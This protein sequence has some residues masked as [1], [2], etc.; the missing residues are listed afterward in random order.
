[1]TARTARGPALAAL[2][3][4]AFA[5]CSDED[6][7]AASTTVVT[8]IP[9]TTT[10]E[11]DDQVL[12]LGA[13]LPLSGAGAEL[14]ASMLAAVELAVEQ[15]NDAGGVG[16]APVELVTADEGENAV[17][18]TRGVEELTAADVDA[19]IGPASSVVALDVLVTLR[20]E[21]VLTCSPSATS[22]ALD[23]FPDEGLFFRT[24]PSDS[25]QAEAIARLIDQTGRAS[26]SILYVDD[27]YGRPLTNALTARLSTRAVDVEALVPFHTDDTDYEDEVASALDSGA[28]V[29]AVIGDPS[30]GARVLATA[31]AE[32]EGETLQII[33]NDALR[34]ASTGNVL[35]SFDE[36][37]IDRVTGV[38]VRAEVV[39]TDLREQLDARQAGSSGLF[40]TN[41]LECVDLIA[42]AAVMS[43]STDSTDIATR[44]TSVAAGGQSCI[45][46]AACAAALDEGRNINYDGPSGFVQISPDGDLVRGVYDV[47]G[48]DALGRD[49]VISLLTVGLDDAV[50]L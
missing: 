34:G 27:A 17:A 12:R 44:I 39:D 2:V 29:L 31:L 11:P 3:A 41:A 1:M 32:T 24:V 49:R 18:A 8:T 21:R 13:L 14:G 30:A 47:F 15:I 45:T 50:T 48:F 35:A 37:E 43:E 6:G 23:D 42:L 9:A 28:Q 4:L 20:R 40:A 22:L 46:F 5:G 19:V 10:T 16:G 36:A 33:V 26:V 7:S 38:A 25:A